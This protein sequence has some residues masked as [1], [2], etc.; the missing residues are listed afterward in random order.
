MWSA[1]IVVTVIYLGLNAVVLYS[2]APEMLI[3][4]QDVFK[5]SANALG[6]RAL[7]N[8]VTGVILLSLATS[9]SAMLQVGPHVYAQMAKERL[10][11]GWLAV[12]VAGVP[13]RALLLQI[14]LAGALALFA[15]L[16]RLLD[17][18]TF[19]LLIS[20][21]VSVCCL[22]LP[23]LR[24][25]RGLRPV[26]L[27][28]LTPLAFVVVSFVIAGMSFHYRWSSDPWGLIYACLVLPVGIFVYPFLARPAAE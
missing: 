16:Q 9:V 5:I 3:N 6:G 22:F 17:Y 10:L 14:F 15:N 21:A 20:S 28:P 27:W 11:P 25:K 13:R 24:G 4:Q 7:E 26:P 12:E 2:V 18:L 8:G 19:L 23:A 1:T